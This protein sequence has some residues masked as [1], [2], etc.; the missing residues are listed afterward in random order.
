MK[1]RK[2]IERIE[3]DG[4]LKVRAEFQI[5]YSQLETKCSEIY[6]KGDY[7]DWISRNYSFYEL[8]KNSITEIIELDYIRNN[9]QGFKVNFTVKNATDYLRNN[10]G[11]YNFINKENAVLV[12]IKQIRNNFTHIDGKSELKEEQYKRNNILLINSLDI[13]KVILTKLEK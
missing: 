7:L 4:M 6:G 5:F 9:S 11:G 10:K 3:K 2:Y 8:I 12:L 13:I 1:A